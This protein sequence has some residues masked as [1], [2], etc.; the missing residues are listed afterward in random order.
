MIGMH[1]LPTKP[2][3]DYILSRYPDIRER[4]LGY[5]NRHKSMTYGTLSVCSGVSTRT[6]S[7]LFTGQPELFVNTA[8]RI[9]QGLGIHPAEIWEDW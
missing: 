3:T 7:R 8:E 4:T 2:L 6:F 9:C 1:L 5:D